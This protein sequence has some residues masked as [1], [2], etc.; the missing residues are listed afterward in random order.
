MFGIFKNKKKTT[1]AFVCKGDVFNTADGQVV[2]GIAFSEIKLN[3]VFVL[4]N[5]TFKVKKI[6]IFK[7]GST[8]DKIAVPAGKNC[9]IC[10]NKNIKKFLINSIVK[11]TDDDLKA[12]HPINFD[13]SC[14]ERRY[15]TFFK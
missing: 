8:E 7:N 5:K 15:V 14:E 10:F 13:G 11:L 6:Q 2:V 3:D 4:N 1:P 12:N 9:A